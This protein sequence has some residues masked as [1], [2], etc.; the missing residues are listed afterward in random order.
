MVNVN[1]QSLLMDIVS[2]VAPIIIEKSR[3]PSYKR[4]VKAGGGDVTR[5]IDWVAE[6]VII[7]KIRDEGLRAMVITEERGIVKVNDGEPEYL[8]I[9][10]PL[11]GSLNFVLDVPF[12]SVSIAVAKYKDNLTLSDVYAGIIHHVSTGTTYYA[13]KGKGA[14]VN[15]EPAS[16]DSSILDKPVASIYIEPTVN[17]K[18]L[19]GLTELYRR[20]NG[21]KIRSLGSASLE[22]TMAALGKLLFFLD[23]RNRLRL[24]DIAAA[25]V[26]AKELN[27]LVLAIDERDIGEIPI[28]EQPRVSL[29]VTR[30]EEVAK[31]LSPFLG[32]TH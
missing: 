13:E 25:Y 23:V 17:S 24:Y 6:G 22:I 18:V 28:N 21:F 7:D 14:Y 27:S 5:G 19:T 3:D 20:L 4:I 31:V 16:F 29:L 2:K 32:N 1:V 8:F 26:I 15:G 9:V 11:D 10:D 30:S 12:Y